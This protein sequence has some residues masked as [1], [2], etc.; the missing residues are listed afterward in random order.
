MIQGVL[1]FDLVYK[2]FK[3]LFS[4]GFGDGLLSVETFGGLFLSEVDEGV[5]TDSNGLDPK[6]EKLRL[7]LSHE[8]I[9][10]IDNRD[11]L[12]RF[13]F[14]LEFVLLFGLSFFMVALEFTK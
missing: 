1:D 9:L 5:S 8:D 6:E 11:D 7:R 14:D 4:V 10:L 13:M 2:L 12:L 3:V